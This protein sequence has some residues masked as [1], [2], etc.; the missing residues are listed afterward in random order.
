M[1]VPGSDKD[2]MLYGT[3]EIIQIMENDKGGVMRVALD[4]D[5]DKVIFVNYLG[6]NDFVEDDYVTVYGYCDGSY[7][8]TSTIGASVTLPRIDAMYLEKA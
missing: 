3:G 5:Y 8:Y 1:D 7:T 2:E 4:G 6:S